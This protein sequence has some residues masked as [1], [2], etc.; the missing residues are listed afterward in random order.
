MDDVSYLK[1][2]ERSKRR[3]ADITKVT[4]IEKET[5]RR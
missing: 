2:Q 3:K 1:I 4:K 5:L